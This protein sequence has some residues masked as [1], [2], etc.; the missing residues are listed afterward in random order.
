MR[1]TAGQP[2]PGLPAAVA[3]LVVFAAT[4]AVGYLYIAAQSRSFDTTTRSELAAIANMKVRQLTGWREDRLEDAK[5]VQLNPIITRPV[6]EHLNN[7]RGKD[8]IETWIGL[9]VK[10][11]HYT[12]ASLWDR[13]GRRRI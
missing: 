3:C 1:A 9:L 10:A 4:A 11:N 8:E 2:L 13:G 7:G 5:V 6:L 12:A